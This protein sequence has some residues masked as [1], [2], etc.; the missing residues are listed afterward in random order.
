MCADASTQVHCMVQL[1]NHQPIM[2][3]GRHKHAE[4]ALLIL[5]F[6]EEEKI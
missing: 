3:C 2:L 5:I 1:S 4:Q 6:Y